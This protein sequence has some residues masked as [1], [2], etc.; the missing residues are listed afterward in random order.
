MLCGAAVSDCKGFGKR[1]DIF[2]V[3]GR[4]KCSVI[5]PTLNETHGDIIGSFAAKRNGHILPRHSRDAIAVELGAVVKCV[6]KLIIHTTMVTGI[7][8]INA[9]EPVR[10]IGVAQWHVCSF[11]TAEAQIDSTNKSGVVVHTNKLLMMRPIQIHIPWSVT[12]NV[13]VGMQAFEKFFGFST[14]GL[15]RSWSFLVENN[16]HL[17][18]FLS[19]VLKQII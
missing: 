2:D 14:V 15:Q 7:V 6:A 3:C 13:D 9:D 4:L 12:K 18:T 1:L 16:V 10:H 17:D 19:D 11:I 5:V 8:I